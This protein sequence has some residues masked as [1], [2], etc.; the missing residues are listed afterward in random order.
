MTPVPRVGHFVCRW[1]YAWHHLRMSAR[2][3]QRSAASGNPV[4][5]KAEL[6]RALRTH[7]EDDLSSIIDSHRKT[8]AGAIHEESKA[9]NDKDTRALESTYL[10]RG[11]AQRASQ[12]SEANTRLA[13]LSV[14]SFADNPSVAIGAL[15]ELLD[16]DEDSYHWY[17]LAPTGGGLSFESCGQKIAILTPDA[18]LGQLLMGKESEESCELRTPVGQRNFEISGVW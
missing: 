17:F 9:E 12:L 6:L 2:K 11:L 18:P 3:A 15:V 14:P 13:N 1:A 7:I 5:D 4:P 10:A 8:H 16:E